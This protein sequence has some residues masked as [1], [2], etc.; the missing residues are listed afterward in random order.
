MSVYDAMTAA[1][2]VMES[3]RTMILDIYWQ[4]NIMWTISYHIHY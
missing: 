4:V 1:M 2:E 3:I